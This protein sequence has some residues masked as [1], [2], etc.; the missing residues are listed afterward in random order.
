MQG[1][2]PR[3]SFLD[4][5]C[6]MEQYDAEQVKMMEERVIALDVEDNVIGSA[7][8]KESHL[9][10]SNGKSMLHRAFSV[11]LFS[12]D[13]KSL[14][15]QRRSDEKITCECL[16]S[17]PTRVRSLLIDAATA[18]CYSRQLSPFDLTPAGRPSCCC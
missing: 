13:G 7:T 9:L 5:V 1:V 8:K 18:G 12:P 11:F 3:T 16:L 15:M 6:A 17:L 10:D 2:S 4:L 14:L